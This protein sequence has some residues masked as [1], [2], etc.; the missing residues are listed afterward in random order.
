M[1]GVPAEDREAVAGA[2]TRAVEERGDYEIQHRIVWRDGTVR[3]IEQRG[4]VIPDVSG[5]AAHLIGIVMDITARQRTD[6][7][8]AARQSVTRVPAEAVTL[9]EATQA[10]MQAVST[11]VEWEV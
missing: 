7:P 9:Q 5:R 8:Q 4:Q 6:A 3:W 11:S 1:E 2:V 10:I